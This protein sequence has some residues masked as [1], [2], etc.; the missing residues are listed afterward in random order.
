[1]Y[2]FTDSGG[3]KALIFMVNRK[4]I[5]KYLLLFEQG[6]FIP[7]VNRGGQE[8]IEIIKRAIRRANAQVIWV[9]IINY[10]SEK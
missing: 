5:G 1:M 8:E 4:K 7:N 9:G 6:V 10:I 2:I 3:L